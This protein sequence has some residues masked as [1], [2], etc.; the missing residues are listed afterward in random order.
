MKEFRKI[1]ELKNWDKNPR[2]IKEKDFER[3]KKHI[4]DH[5][6]MQPLVITPDGEVLGGNMRLRVYDALN[7]EDVWVE[8]VTPKDEAD[9]LRIALVLNDRA[10]FYDSDLLANLMPQYPDFLWE[11]YAVDMGTPFVI[12]DLE[13]YDIDKMQEWQGMPEFHQDNKTAYKQVLVSFENQED[14]DNFSQLVEQ[15]ITD[16]TRYIWYPKQEKV[17]VKDFVV[18][19]NES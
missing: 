18:V 13:K 15:E 14:M 16:K 2:S 17:K 4:I 10:G 8:V 11:D 7:I 5:G 12:A 3:L 9:K 1:T 19:S 6:Q